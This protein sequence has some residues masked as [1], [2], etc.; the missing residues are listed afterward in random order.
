MPAQVKWVELGR[1]VFELQLVVRSL[2]ISKFVRSFV[3][4]G[5]LMEC[6]KEFATEIKVLVSAYVV[7]FVL[8]Y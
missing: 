3:R 6:C 5:V 8:T 7:N 4:L 2:D 1:T